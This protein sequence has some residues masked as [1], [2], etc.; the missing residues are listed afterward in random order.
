LIERELDVWRL[1]RDPEGTRG[2]VHVATLTTRRSFM[3]MGAERTLR[4]SNAEDA[5]PVARLQA[6][7]IGQ[8][9]SCKADAAWCQ[10]QVG[11]HRGWL[12]R[13]EFWGTLPNEA[14]N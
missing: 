14:V 13:D 10:V 8:I 11:E 12:K 2:W 5:R 7:V 1:V 9:R 6:G 3:V 4:R